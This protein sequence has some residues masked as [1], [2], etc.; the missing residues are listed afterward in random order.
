MAWREKCVLNYKIVKGYT[1]NR[2]W[3]RVMVVMVV[4]VVLVGNSMRSLYRI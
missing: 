2:E 3:G 1:A 4:V